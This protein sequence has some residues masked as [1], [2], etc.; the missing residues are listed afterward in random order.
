MKPLDFFL[1]HRI[2][3]FPITSGTKT[4]AVPKGT[5]WNTWD[6][7]ARP[8]PNGPYGVVLGQLLVIDAD[9]P[10]TAALV[11]AHVPATPFTV[12][13]S[14]Y[15]G[16]APGRG[17]HHYFR[18]P[19]Q[20]TPA[21]IRRDG[22]VI[23]ARRAGQYVL[24]PGSP[25]PSCCTYDASDWS[26]SLADVPAFP[27][28]FVFTDTKISAVTSDYQTYVPPTAMVK[29]ERSHELFRLVRHLK[30]KGAS[31]ETARFTVELYNRERCDPPKSDA[32]IASWFPRAWGHRDRGDF[33]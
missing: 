20:P 2:A 1:A 12:Q 30:A 27:A 8:R 6:D 9:S 28:D 15:H 32:W 29:G 23:E 11:S 25:H 21:F 17:R 33:N 19:D 13:S 5:H 4:P 24:G 18:A 7:F 26:W 31:I 22:L 16:G 14:P 3:V 10:D